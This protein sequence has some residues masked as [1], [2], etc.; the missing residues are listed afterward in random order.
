MNTKH[1]IS[2]V[3]TSGYDSIE[4]LVDRHVELSWLSSIRCRVV[5][6]L[7]SPQLLLGRKTGTDFLSVQGKQS[8]AAVNS[9][10]NP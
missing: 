1:A 10:A 8:Q 3:L 4:N 6:R 9:W 5:V 2:P 7:R